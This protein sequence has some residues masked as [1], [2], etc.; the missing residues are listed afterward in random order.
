MRCDMSDQS[1]D[2]NASMRNRKRRILA[3]GFLTACAIAMFGWLTG[4]GWAIVSVVK[5]L[6][7]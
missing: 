2:R 4:L 7:D 1:S 5:W 3:V 6:F